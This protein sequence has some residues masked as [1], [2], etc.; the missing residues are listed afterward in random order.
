[1][2]N[3]RWLGRGFHP[4]NTLYEN[5]TETTCKNTKPKVEAPRPC[6]SQLLNVTIEF[7][8]NHKQTGQ[9]VKTYLLFVNSNVISRFY[10]KNFEINVHNCNF[11]QLIQNIYNSKECAIKI[12]PKHTQVFKCSRGIRQGCPLSPTLFNNYIDD[13]IDELEKTNPAPLTLQDKNISCLMCADDI[14]ILSS[15]HKGLQDCLDTLP[16]FCN[17]WKLSINKS[18]SECT[19]FYKSKCKYS[20]NF[21]I[22]DTPLKKSYRIYILRID[23]RCKMFL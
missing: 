21:F 19:T 18:K 3:P 8:P 1:M 15:S 11:I 9:Q 23:C 13:L 4:T 22:D 17:N 6:R 14:I 5:E 7:T 12:G 20:R 16:S 2:L 10:S